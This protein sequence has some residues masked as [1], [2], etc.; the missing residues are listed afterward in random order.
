[1][2]VLKVFV[3]TQTTDSAGRGLPKPITTATLLYDGKPFPEFGKAQ[4]QFQVDLADPFS[5]PV[6]NIVSDDMIGEMD[7]TTHSQGER[8]Q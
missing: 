1:M 4:F 5:R 3:E 2:P 6:Y 7:I 8:D